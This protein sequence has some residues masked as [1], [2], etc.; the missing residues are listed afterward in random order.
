MVTEYG[1]YCLEA[2]VVAA[3]LHLER[4]RPGSHPAKVRE[5]H[6]LANAYGLPDIADTLIDLN[7]MRKHVA[8]GDVD[9][10][11]DLDPEDVAALID[12]FVG[13][14]AELLRQ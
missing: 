6:H 11:E 12:D 5:S 3:A 7:N 2:G 10:P 1:F 8:Y 9:P 13:F 14:V 4:S